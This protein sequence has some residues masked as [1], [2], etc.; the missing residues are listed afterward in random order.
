MTKWS[1]L[2]GHVFSDECK[3]V[4]EKKKLKKGG[5]FSKKGM[6]CL[7]ISNSSIL[8]RVKLPLL[9]LHYGNSIPE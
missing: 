2:E 4:F 5:V 1:T 7:T 8:T 9:P 3:Y 6:V